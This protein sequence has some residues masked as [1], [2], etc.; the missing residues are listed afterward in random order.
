[1]ANGGTDE[2]A[3]TLGFLTAVGVPGGGHVGGL[4]V[5]DRRG[6]PLEFQCTTPVRP[7]ATQR[8]LFGPTL[9]PYLLGEVIGGTLLKKAGVKPDVVLCEGAA[10][11]A[12]RPL[13][14]RP[15]ARVE[16]DGAPADQAAGP[17]GG[18]ALAVGGRTLHFHPAHGTDRQFLADRADRLPEHADL[19]EP[20]ER[21]REALAETTR[22][23]AA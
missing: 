22:A 7:D 8:T 11:L 2:Q 5:T 21:V 17:E 6:R 20:F 4:L 12:L 19:A 16:S 14:D 9:L 3:L 10:V 13:T 18:S 1:M 15:V 23:V